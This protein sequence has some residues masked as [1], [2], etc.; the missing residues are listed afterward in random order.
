MQKHVQGEFTP[1]SSYVYTSEA[2]T[3]T[4][5]ESEN[6][7]ASETLLPLPLP[8]PLETQHHEIS[9]INENVEEAKDPLAQETERKAFVAPYSAWD[10][11]R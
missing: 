1:V 4:E 3:P 5:P 6:P 11:S 8:L 7:T 10:P 9:E 2:P